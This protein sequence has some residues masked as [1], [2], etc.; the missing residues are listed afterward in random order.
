MTKEKA[1]K[2]LNYWLGKYLQ[3]KRN[4]GYDQKACD[5]YLKYRAIYERLR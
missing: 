3:A 4:G 1:F 2:K 5:K